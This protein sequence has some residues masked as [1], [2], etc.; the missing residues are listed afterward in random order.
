[1]SPL[2][3]ATRLGKCGR[4]PRWQLVRYA[5]AM[6]E[7]MKAVRLWGR[8][9]LRLEDLD[10]PEPSA[11]EDLVR[12]TAVGLCGSDLHWFDEGGIGGTMVERPL[13]PGHE[14]AGV[15]KDGRRV[16]VDPAIP[17]DECEACRHGYTNLCERVVFAGHDVDGALR[18]WVAWPRRNLH[19][20]PDGLSDADGAMLEP[21]GVSLHACRLAHIPLG[22]TVGV[23]GCGPIGWL[24]IQVARLLGASRVVA[25]ELPSRPWRAAAAEA[26]G[27]IVVPADGREAAAIRAATGGRGLDVAIE[28]A[29]DNAAVDAAIEAVRPGARVVLAG[30]PP[31]ARTSVP[32][33]AA[34]RKGLTLAWSRRM[35]DTYA[36][37][38]DLVSRGM[39]DV[40]SGI[41]HTFDLSDAARA[42]EAASRR[43]GMKVVVGRPG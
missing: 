15:T 27:A 21:L 1:M 6:R 11:D 32:A 26:K 25:T 3:L 40:R 38:I 20:L 14:F 22:A 7:T 4:P 17:C 5:G 37:A 10:V 23:F 42:F 29:G 33:A 2:S 35:P 41:T 43:E 34:R 36:W 39:I 31:D 18:E 9:D 16:A 12:V 30:I 19:P 28:V 24:T 8:R 13:V